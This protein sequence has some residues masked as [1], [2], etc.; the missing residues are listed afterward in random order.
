L[1]GELAGLDVQLVGMSGGWG[2]RIVSEQPNWQHFQ[3]CTLGTECNL[4]GTGINVRDRILSI[5]SWL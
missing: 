5:R 3:A 4:N 1:G 2:Q